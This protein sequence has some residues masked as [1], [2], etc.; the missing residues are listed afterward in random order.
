M[1]QITSS[2]WLLFAV[3]WLHLQVPPDLTKEG[4]MAMTNFERL[5][6]P[7]VGKTGHHIW[8]IVPE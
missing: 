3:R 7:I 1:G 8:E 5:R 6:V 2:Q 4:G